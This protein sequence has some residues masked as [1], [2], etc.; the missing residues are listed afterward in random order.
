MPAV[1]AAAAK[2]SRRSASDIFGHGS[3]INSQN[4]VKTLSVFLTSRAKFAGFL[5]G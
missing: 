4:L 1:P 5:S 2:L 3:G